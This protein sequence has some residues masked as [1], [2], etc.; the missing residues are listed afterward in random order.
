MSDSFADHDALWNLF[1]N[2]GLSYF[3]L[4]S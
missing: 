1:R 4:L 2:L 3:I